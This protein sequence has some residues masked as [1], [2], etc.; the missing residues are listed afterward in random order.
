MKR[1]HGCLNPALS[2][3]LQFGGAVFAYESGAVSLIDSSMTG[4]WAGDVRRQPSS[5][6]L[7]PPTAASPRSFLATAVRR[8]RLRDF[9]RCGLTNRLDRDGLHG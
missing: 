7:Q 6:P 2:S 3:R 4:C 9:Q 1:G 8:R 5:P